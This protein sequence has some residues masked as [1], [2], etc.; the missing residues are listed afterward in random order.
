MISV[1]FSLIGYHLLHFSGQVYIKNLN[2]D[3]V[4]FSVEQ[5]TTYDHSYM[6]WALAMGDY[7]SDGVQG[8]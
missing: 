8:K 5:N 3:Y 1:C 2:R 7:D 4:D 6:G